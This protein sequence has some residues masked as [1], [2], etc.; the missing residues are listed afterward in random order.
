MHKYTIRNFFI[1]N[2][3]EPIFKDDS[4]GMDM[5]YLKKNLYKLK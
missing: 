3:K 1:D 5:I 2:Y 4:K